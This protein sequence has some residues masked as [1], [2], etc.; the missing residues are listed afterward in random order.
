M[1]KFTIQDFK[2]DKELLNL[3]SR[4]IISYLLTLN[5]FQVFYSERELIDVSDV[6]PNTIKGSLV[7]LSKQQPSNYNP[8][9]S[10]LTA[11]EKEKSHTASSSNKSTNTH[12]NT[13]PPAS[14][15]KQNHPAKIHLHSM[16]YSHLNSS[17]LRSKVKT[18][19]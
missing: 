8:S 16:I 1:L 3:S 10:Q 12:K 17:R 4:T 7:I 2:D 19:S 5:A 9:P 6:T 14:N 13:A 11:S 15:P 18:S